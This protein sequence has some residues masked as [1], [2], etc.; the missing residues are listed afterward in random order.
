MLKC[1]HY[2]RWNQGFSSSPPSPRSWQFC[3]RYPES[4][5]VRKSPCLL[6]TTQK[7]PAGPPLGSWPLLVTSKASTGRSLLLHGQPQPLWLG[8][9]AHP[10]VHGCPQR[11][12]S[13]ARATQIST[14]VPAKVRATYRRWP[15][16]MRI[17]QITLRSAT[18]TYVLR[19]SPSLPSGRVYHPHARPRCVWLCGRWLGLHLRRCLRVWHRLPQTF[20]SAHK[21][22]F[23]QRKT[24]AAKHLALE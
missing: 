5:K 1:Y 15:I 4:P 17:S 23:E 13:Q 16:A 14:M 3:F 6:R 18:T 22:P 11:T 7:H 2:I 21:A 24:G 20:R 9:G 12:S 19:G 8:G 10:R